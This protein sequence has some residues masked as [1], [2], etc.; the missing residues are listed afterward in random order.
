MEKVPKISTRAR[1]MSTVPANIIR[2]ILCLGVK[3]LGPSRASGHWVKM[4]R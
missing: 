2:P 3:F 1:A 4:I